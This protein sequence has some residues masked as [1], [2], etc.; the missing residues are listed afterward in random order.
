MLEV[1]SPSSPPHEAEIPIENFCLLGE[2]AEIGR[3]A[4]SEN[5]ILFLRTGSSQVA[6]ELKRWYWS[7]VGNATVGRVVR[8]QLVR[9]S[10]A[11]WSD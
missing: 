7:S 10:L 11:S 6:T 1:V 2:P 3:Q 8:G 4:D 9:W 5:E